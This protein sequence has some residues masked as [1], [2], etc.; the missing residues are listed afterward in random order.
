MDIERHIPDWVKRLWKRPTHEL[1]RWQ[2]TVKFSVDLGRHGARELRHDR[3]GQMA[4]ALTYHTLF[5]LLP[6]LVLAMVVLQTFVGEAERQQFKESVVEFI[7]PRT[8]TTAVAAPEPEPVPAEPELEPEPGQARADEQITAREELAEARQDLADRI[9]GL[10]NSLETIN[11][12]GIGVVGLLVFIY[13][14][15]GLLATVE[16]SFNQIYTASHARPWYIR[17]PLYYT[18]IT[19]GPIVLIF[20][21]VLQEMMFETIRSGAWTNWLAGPMV[22]ITP[23][24]S[25]WI[26]LFLLYLLLPNTSVSKQTAAIGSLVAAILWVVTK[27][28]FRYFVANAAIT[29]W[30]GALAV[31]PLFLLWLY[32]TWLI[33]LFGLELTY[34]LQAMR[35]RK[36]DKETTG[37]VEENLIDLAW[38]APMGAQLARHFEQGRT[39][40][41]ADL[42]RAVSL[43]QRTISRLLQMLEAANIVH[44]VETSDNSGGYSLARP[45]EHITVTEVFDA[46]RHVMPH[47]ESRPD[48]T[49]GWA[50]VDR[51][52]NTIRQQATDVTLAELADD[53]DEI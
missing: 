17:L 16:R 20:G 29:S 45:A 47:P 34:T 44:R 38:L 13:G 42:A 4:A 9:E 39:T 1:T 40:K 33:V 46:A 15:T 22:V 3:A 6:T 31:L 35:G 12:G 18:V 2:R 48:A 52:Q 51:L 36:F 37:R 28:L 7:L 8:E 23:I 11:F 43:P 27:E 21:Q 49:A 50:F 10:M 24:V 25:A 30:Y 14:A 26:V 5:S 32:L 19:L 41:A 53:E